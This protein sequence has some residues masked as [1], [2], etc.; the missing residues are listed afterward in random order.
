MMRNNKFFDLQ[1]G[2]FFF[3]VIIFLNNNNL[4]AEGDSLLMNKKKI[5][6][7]TSQASKVKEIRG[8]QLIK[9]L[10]YDYGNYIKEF[11]RNGNEILSMNK[12]V[13][14]KDEQIEMKYDD[15]N[16]LIEKIIYDDIGED[17]ELRYSLK[18]EYV[19][20]TL[21]QV[22]GFDDDNELT[23]VAAY[24][25]KVGE[26]SVFEY[27]AKNMDDSDEYIQKTFNEN[28]KEISFE[29]DME[30]GQFQSR[31]LSYYNSDNKL[32]EVVNYK[33][34]DLLFRHNFIFE[35]DTTRV[36]L[37][38]YYNKEEKKLIWVRHY[39]NLDDVTYFKKFDDDPKRQIINI[40]KYEYDENGNW[41]KREKYS[42]NTLIEIVERKIEYYD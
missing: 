3:L 36:Q 5:M 27:D 17:K 39:N 8:R 37:Y 26:Y 2:I 16:R 11:D 28:G 42:Y 18:Y 14:G 6:K 20:D 25:Y 40:F 24:T 33:G 31:R 1:S 35:A 23:R 10:E 32:D 12:F 9:E 29:K 41:I 7:I 38:G 34:D 19:D 4:K 21:R 22:R 13:D 30:D 15:K